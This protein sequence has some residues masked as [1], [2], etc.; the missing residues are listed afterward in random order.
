MNEQIEQLL[1]QSM[2]GLARADYHKFAQLTSY[3]GCVIINTVNN[4]QD[5]YV[6]YTQILLVG[7]SFFVEHHES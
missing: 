6:Q 3:S 4:K 5:Y 2:N 1:K 7:E